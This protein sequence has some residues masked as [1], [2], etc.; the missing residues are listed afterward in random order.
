MTTLTQL[1]KESYA[2]V[3]VH[4]IFVNPSVLKIMR[5]LSEARE[6]NPLENIYHAVHIVELTVGK[7]T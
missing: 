3:L 5:P 6:Y 7:I 2:V 1:D 4:W